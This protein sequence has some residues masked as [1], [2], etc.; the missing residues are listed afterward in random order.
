MNWQIGLCQMCRNSYTA[1][2]VVL[3]QLD[4]AIKCPFN[5]FVIIITRLL[6]Q[7]ATRYV[8]SS[9]LTGLL[10]RLTWFSF[11]FLDI[12][13]QF[14]KPTVAHKQHHTMDHFHTPSFGD[15]DFSIPQFNH[16]LGATNE[17]ATS[18]Y[19]SLAK[20][21]SSPQYQNHWNNEVPMATY[22][23]F[24]HNHIQSHMLQSPMHPQQHHI[25]QSSPPSQH[26]QQQPV[27]VQQMHNVADHEPPMGTTVAQLYGQSPTNESEENGFI[28]NNKNSNN[29]RPSP[30]YAEVD[31]QTKATPAKKAKPVKKKAK[32]D[33]NEPQK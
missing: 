9:S 3:N 29:K 33:P 23:G 10:H 5:D 18:D 1:K 11:F 8:F 32:K 31:E 4:C 27:A 22:G 30:T 26:H 2:C 20:S 6:E 25:H 12:L 19:N 7:L 13:V 15:E 17:V 14:L 28:N 21:M 16:H 24:N